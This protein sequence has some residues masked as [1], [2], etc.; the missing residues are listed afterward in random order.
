VRRRDFIALAGGATIWPLAVEAQ[1]PD[2]IRL[3]GVLMASR[4]DDA[5]SEARLTAFRQGLADRGWV[6]GRNVHYEVRYAGGNRERAQAGAAALVKL[7]PDVIFSYGTVS[8]AALK[9]ATQSI[10]IVFAVVN[11]PVAQ[12]YVPN[13]AHPGGNITGFSYIDY[14]MIG[15]ALGF[16]KQIAPAVT[17]VGFLF[18]PDDYPYYEVYLRTFQ[19][20]REALSLDVIPMRVHSDAEIEAAIAPFSATPGSGLITPPSAFNTVHRHAI[21]EQ[22]LQ[23][24]LPAVV[25]LRE[26]VVE[27]GLM[28]YAPD[29]TDIFRR[30]M[31]YVDRILK[32][33]KPG[34]L[35]V[36]APTKFEFVINLK[37]AKILGLDVPASL[38]AL[39]DEVI[40]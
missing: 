25:H 40:E 30:A 4:Q 2:K 15:K 17:R 10:P 5:V 7:A 27:G 32:G 35:P 8:V 33:E 19:E 31:P 24:K 39:A 28:C 37:T 21:V 12:G 22:A 23:H 1:A 9:A 16:F 36:Q 11:D 20:Q 14:S 3:I 18:N 6:D 29:E 38:L 13:V 26:A 34:D